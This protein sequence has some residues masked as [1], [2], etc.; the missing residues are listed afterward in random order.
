MSPLPSWVTIR[1]HSAASS[2]RICPSRESAYGSADAPGAIRTGVVGVVERVGERGDGL[3]DPQGG[4]PLGVVRAC[5]SFGLGGE[6]FLG[7]GD[8]GL[9]HAV[10]AAGDLGVDAD[11]DF[12]GGRGSDD[13]DFERGGAFV[14]CREEFVHLLDVG[15]QDSGDGGRGVDRNGQQ[16]QRGGERAT[17]GLQGDI[18]I[19]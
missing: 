11:G 4:H 2:S 18:D 12:G 1:S 6:G 3:G 13:E 5:F 19:P 17:G 8:A 15:V 7:D 9:V 10:V 16:G 14:G